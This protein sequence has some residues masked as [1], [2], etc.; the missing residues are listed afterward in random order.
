MDE[1]LVL[2]VAAPPR[3]HARWVLRGLGGALV[4]TGVVLAAVE[5]SRTGAWMPVLIRLGLGAFG[6][7]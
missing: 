4:V 3:P 2:G 5:V 7:G 6:W 1:P